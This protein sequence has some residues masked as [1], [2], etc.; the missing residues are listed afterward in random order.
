MNPSVLPMY[1]VTRSLSAVEQGDADA[2]Q[3]LLP[4]IYEELRQLAAWNL[5]QEQQGQTLQAVTSAHK[6]TRLM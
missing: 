2:A 3:Q 6:K 5:A 1:E 4:L